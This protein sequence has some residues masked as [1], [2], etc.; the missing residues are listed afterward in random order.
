VKLKLPG[1]AVTDELMQK[2]PA[3]GNLHVMSKVIPAAQ[4]PPFLGD[5]QFRIK[6]DAAADFTALQ[7]DDIRRLYLVLQFAIL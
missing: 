7:P 4:A 1:A 5:F 2:A 6:K 3:F